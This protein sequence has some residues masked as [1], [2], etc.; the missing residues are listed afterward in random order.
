[1]AIMMGGRRLLLKRNKV[2]PCRM[3][4]IGTGAGM[5]IS[6]AGGVAVPGL[7]HIIKLI[8]SSG[9]QNFQFSIPQ[10]IL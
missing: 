1:M 4:A 2:I 7:G 5:Q 3:A 9:L 6:L 8:N 10:I